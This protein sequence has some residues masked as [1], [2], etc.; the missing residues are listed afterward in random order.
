ME[1][2][3]RCTQGYGGETR[4]APGVECFLRAGLGHES[5]ITLSA[6]V[7]SRG[8]SSFFLVSP[9]SAAPKLILQS[10]EQAA[11]FAFDLVLED[12]TRKV[13]LSD[14]APPPFRHDA[15]APLELEMG[16]GI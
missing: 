6:Y 13:S 16:C 15:L 1:A 12:F 7:F 14:A 2:G 9:A 4:R 8:C 5:V 11:V 3:G 10:H